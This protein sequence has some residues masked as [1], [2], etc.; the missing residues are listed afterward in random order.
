MISSNERFAEGFEG[1]DSV[2]PAAFSNFARKLRLYSSRCKIG[3]SRRE[4]EDASLGSVGGGTEDRRWNSDC[5]VS[6]L[7]E[8]FWSFEEEVENRWKRE[9]F[10]SDLCLSLATESAMRGEMQDL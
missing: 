9:G 8:S 2:P 3:S 7:S 1:L 5:G 10:T 6:L 4:C